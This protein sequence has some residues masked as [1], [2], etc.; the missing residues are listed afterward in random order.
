M[1]GTGRKFAIIPCMAH[2]T[3]PAPAPAP[4]PRPGPGP[5][6]PAATSAKPRGRAADANTQKR[7]LDRERFRLL[8]QIE[9]KLEMPMVLLGLAWLV[10]LVIDLTRGLTAGLELAGT[11]IW[12][13]FLLDFAL[14]FTLAPRKWSYVKRNWLTVIALAVPALRVFRVA[15]AFAVLRAARAARGVRLVRVVG[16]LNRGMRALGATMG[17]RGFGYVIALTTIVTL[18]GAAGMYAFE[19]ANP[20]GRGLNDYGAA[21]WWTAM[22]MTTMGSE[23]WPQTA[24]GRVLCV[25]LALY[26]FAVFGYVTATLAS[27]FI[28]RDAENDE[29]EVAGERSIQSLRAEIAALRAEIRRAL[30]PE[31][32]GS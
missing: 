32:G 26:A 3:P 28:G 11:I 21:L 16:S 10:L 31:T 18:A 1:I 2:T 12:V 5:V 30:P 4:G 22:I 19:N 8:R 15:R 6:T 27:F 17:R 14:K 29:T 13:A 7:A 9:Q 24:E 25:L 23:Y 20:D